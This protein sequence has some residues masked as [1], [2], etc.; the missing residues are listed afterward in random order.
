MARWAIRSREFATDPLSLSSDQACKPPP[1]LQGIAHFEHQ[2][3]ELLGL[4]SAVL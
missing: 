3:S 4:V 1:L 2:F